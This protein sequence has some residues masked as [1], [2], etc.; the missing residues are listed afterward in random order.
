MVKI[1]PGKPLP[2]HTRL[3]Y[4]E[5]CA[6]ITLEELLP[7]QYQNLILADKPDLQ[8]NEVGIEVTIADD[9]KKQEA[10]SNWVRANNTENKKI[11]DSAIERMRQLG[12]EFTGGIQGWPGLTHR[13]GR[14][15]MLLRKRSKSCKPVITGLFHGMSCSY[16]RISGSA[17]KR[18]RR[19]TC[20]SFLVL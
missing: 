12:V 20:S 18:K 1:E 7:A 14:L 2:G 6:K 8:G 11:R 4:D 19:L 17:R 10:V 15:K 9:R 16:L 13:F 3:D 5:C